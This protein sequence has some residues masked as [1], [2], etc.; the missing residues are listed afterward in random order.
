MALPAHTVASIQREFVF[1]TLSL[2]GA[3]NSGKNAA[4]HELEQVRALSQG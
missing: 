4:K 3:D 1:S 2:G